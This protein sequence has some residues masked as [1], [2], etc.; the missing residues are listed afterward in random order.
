M[1]LR[2]IIN[3]KRQLPYFNEK[4]RV[5]LILNL[6]FY[7]LG[8]VLLLKMLFGLCFCMQAGHDPAAL[9]AQVAVENDIAQLQ[10]LIRQLRAN[11][12]L[13]MENGTLFNAVAELGANLTHQIVGINHQSTFAAMG[14]LG[15]QHPLHSLHTFVTAVQSGA[16]SFDGITIHYNE[17][18]LPPGFVNTLPSPAELLN[19]IN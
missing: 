6:I 1:L 13:Q 14:V 4:D 11:E 2:K 16:I 3:K 7:C 15:Q 17:A 19:F 9:G 12:G 8:S 18:A 10:E 5:E